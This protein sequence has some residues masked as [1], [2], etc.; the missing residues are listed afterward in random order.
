MEV[1]PPALLCCYLTAQTGQT[2]LLSAVR[3]AGWG[4][5]ELLTAQSCGSSCAVTTAGS[6]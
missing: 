1:L 4:R 5:T 2:V 6:A 3:H